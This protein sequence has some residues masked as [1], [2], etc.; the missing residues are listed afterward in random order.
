MDQNLVKCTACVK[1]HLTFNN[2]T[3]TFVP[4]NWRKANTASV[5]KEGQ[6]DLIQSVEKR[7]QLS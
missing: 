1:R 3:L 6:S 7:G 2:A 5:L 4:D